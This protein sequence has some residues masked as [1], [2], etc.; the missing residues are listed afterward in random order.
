MIMRPGTPAR[1]L[2]TADTVGGIWTYAIDL[3]EALGSEGVE[4]ALATMGGPASPE[5]RREAQA[6]GT[7]ELFESCYRLPWMD[8]PW[9]DVR[10]AGEWLLEL[11]TRI[12]PNVIHL[13]EPV[14]GSLPWPAPTMAVC[15]SCVLSWWEAVWKSPAPPSWDRY[16]QEMRRG[17]TAA[18]EVVAPSS[19]ML[20][21][22]R[23]H[24]G[25]PKGRVISNGR[26]GDE[27]TPGPKAAVVFAAGR[28]WDP[29]KNLLAL[30]QVA[31][32]LAWPIYVAGEP[33]HPSRDEVVT[34]DHLHLLGQVPSPTVAAWLRRASIYAFPCRY[35]PFGLSVLEAALAGCALVLG[36]LRSLRELWEGAAVFVPPDEPDVLGLAIEGLIDDP[37]LRHALGMRARRR[38]LTLTPRRMA[39]A[40]MQVYSDLLTRRGSCLEETACAS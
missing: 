2:M 11:A 31:G 40:Y 16:R 34:V 10:A 26:K 30:D 14:H 29:A 1:V 7:L 9:E 37:G 3:A 20:E 6:V 15:H 38:A 27:F 17:L 22:M 32:D 35:E 21:S 39:L 19:S 24:Y 4:V 23:L 36:D 12:I 8:Q 33:R 5:Q 25:I 28:L 13:N 18:D